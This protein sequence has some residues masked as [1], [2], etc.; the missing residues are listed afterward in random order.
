MRA[1]ARMTERSPGQREFCVHKE[2]SARKAEDAGRMERRKGAE[3]ESAETRKT[4][5]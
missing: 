3:P 4:N 5:S 2:R 1:Q